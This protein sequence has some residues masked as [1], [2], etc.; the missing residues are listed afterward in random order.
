MILQ[1][2]FSRS[3][4]AIWLLRY[5][6]H[7]KTFFTREYLKLYQCRVNY[8]QKA[9]G[10]SHNTTPHH[11]KHIDADSICQIQLRFLLE[12]IKFNEYRLCVLCHL[13]DSRKSGFY[14]IQQPFKRLNHFAYMCSF[15]CLTIICHI[16]QR[17]N[18]HSYVHWLQQYYVLIFTGTGKFLL[19]W[20]CV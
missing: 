8:F 5:A 15:C 13:V 12:S 18:I 1:I 4:N 16:R 2:R 7:M 20:F 3:S 14:L 10:T 19:S 11:T 17:Y 9:H 6:S